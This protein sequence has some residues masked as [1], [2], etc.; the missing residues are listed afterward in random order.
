MKKVFAVI[1]AFVV[2]IMF[3][4]V[5]KGA[6]SNGDNNTTSTISKRYFSAFKD[7]KWGVIDSQGNTVID[8]VYQEMI[9]IPD[10][11]TDV[12]LC[13]YDVDYNT[14]TYKTK[15]LNSKNDEILTGYD[16]IEA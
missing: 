5:I 10:E 13:T 8:P 14:G 3:I 12:F 6:F 4:F 2:I 11:K 9:V 16:T 1:I 7:E 15:A